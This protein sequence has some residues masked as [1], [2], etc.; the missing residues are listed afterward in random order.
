MKIWIRTDKTRKI[1]E[2]NNPIVKKAKIRHLN[3]KSILASMDLHSTP[4]QYHG[5]GLREKF[6]AG[7]FLGGRMWKSVWRRGYGEEDKGAGLCSR[8]VLFSMV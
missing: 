6:L 2:N 7:V 1:L 3:Q 5:G 8:V 4:M